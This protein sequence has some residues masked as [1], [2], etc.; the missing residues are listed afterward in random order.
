L[1]WIP[2][3]RRIASRWRQ[4]AGCTTQREWIENSILEAEGSGKKIILL[5]HHQLFSAFDHPVM[6]KQHLGVFLREHH[7]HAWFWGHEHVC[8]LYQPTPEVTYARCVGNGGVSSRVKSVNEAWRPQL[9]QLHF[10]GAYREPLDG[11]PAQLFGFAVLDLFGPELTVT[12][13]DEN[14]FEWHRRTSHRIKP[15]PRGAAAF[16]LSGALALIEH[17]GPEPFGSR[18]SEGLPHQQEAKK[19][20][21][22]FPRTRL[23]PGTEPRGRLLVPLP[24]DQL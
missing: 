15:Y 11:Q 10:E 3:G 22:M 2:H 18:A 4:R 1:A 19:M 21:S 12:Y 6:L 7:V 8:T 9:V 14:D 23:R 17:W 20:E 13:V 5:S 16:C 24:A